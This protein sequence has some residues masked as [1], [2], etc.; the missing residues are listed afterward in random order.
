[1][2][3]EPASGEDPWKSYGTAS[4]TPEEPS[5][6][7]AAA[8]QLPAAEQGVGDVPLP[9][10][11]KAKGRGNSGKE[12]DGNTAAPVLPKAKTKDHDKKGK[13]KGKG[14]SMSPEQK[15]GWPCVF[16]YTKEGGSLKEAQAQVGQ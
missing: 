12:D 13:G 10:A 14:K 16:H 15:K 4:L 5:T 9:N 3:P 8:G 6:W 1:M 2:Q 7:D 11:S